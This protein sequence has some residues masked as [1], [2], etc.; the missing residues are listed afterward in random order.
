ML[1]GHDTGVIDAIPASNCAASGKNGVRL[2][3]DGM[4]MDWEGVRVG[5][6]AKHHAP[7]MAPRVEA[8][9]FGRDWRAGGASWQAGGSDFSFVSPSGL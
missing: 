6:I 4:P 5:A 8:G 1:N 2:I 7:R 9:R 3:G